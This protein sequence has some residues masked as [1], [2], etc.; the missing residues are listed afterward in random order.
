MQQERTCME[1]KKVTE[2]EKDDYASFLD[3]IQ[4]EFGEGSVTLLEQDSHKCEKEA[5]SS[6]SF[7]LDNIIWKSKNG[8]GGYVKG[9]IIEISGLQSSGKSTLA[10]H[11]VRECQKLG[12]KVVY[13]DLENGLDLDYVKVIGVDTKKLILPYPCSGEEAFEMLAK[14]VELDIGL[15]VVD[16]VSNLV[17]RAQLETNLEK[18]RI[19]SHA[20]LMSAGLRKVKN[21][22]INKKTVIIF[23]NQLRNNISLN[24][25]GNPEV[26]TGGMA[27]RYESDLRLRLKQKEKIE[28]GG[29]VVGVKIEIKVIKNRFSKPFGKTDVEIILSRGIQ[30]SKEISKV[31]I[32]QDIIIKKNGNSYF[33]KEKKL[34]SS[35]DSIANFLDLPD[36]FE[37]LKEIERQILIA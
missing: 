4:K 7:L 28:R 11:A 14:F 21:K 27:L 6:G 36:N 17:P 31:A 12:E 23:I 33:F 30:K 25:S 1:N 20:A 10:F 24:F 2:N 32:E 19:G 13:F 5:I 35:L 16:S 9:K 15:I 26:T 8:N 29:K 37:T 22:L 3:I 18:T 34:G